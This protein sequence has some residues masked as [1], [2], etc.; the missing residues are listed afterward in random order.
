MTVSV[1]TTLR[2]GDT[3]EVR[4]V[5]RSVSPKQNAEINRK[6]LTKAGLLVQ[7]IVTEEMIVRGRGKNA[8]P[9]PDRLTSRTSTLTRS[10]ALILSR[11]K[12]SIGTDLLY[13]A[14]HELHKSR[15]RPF[16]K[17]G[18]EKAQPQFQRIFISVLEQ[19]LKRA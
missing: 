8:P 7:K 16:L 11:F 9:L 5:L 4:R 6:A 18:L 14:V 2:R 13:G 10:V 15:P 3:A 17:P 12:V 1:S 19:E